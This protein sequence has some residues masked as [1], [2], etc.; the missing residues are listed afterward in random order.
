MSKLFYDHL[1]EKKRFYGLFEE[2]ELGENE[3]QKL[4]DEID[5][6]IHWHILEVIFEVLDEEHHEE[7]L[8]KMH[9]SPHDKALIVFVK[10]KSGVLDLEERI[11]WIIERIMAEFVV[12]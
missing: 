5:E 9:E 3:R 4:R 10:E 7:F 6:V 2:D 11:V 1:I 12:E 8:E